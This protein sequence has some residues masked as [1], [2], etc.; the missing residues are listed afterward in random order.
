[1]KSERDVIAIYSKVVKLLYTFNTSQLHMQKSHYNYIDSL[2]NLLHVSAVD[3]QPQGEQ[4]SRSNYAD[5]GKFH[6]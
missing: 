1:M 6:P 2:L 3:S 5:A 4:L